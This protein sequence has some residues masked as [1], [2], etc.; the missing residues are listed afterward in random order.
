MEWPAAIEFR[1]SRFVEWPAT[2]GF[3]GLA[4]GDFP[5]ADRFLAVSRATF[6]REVAFWGVGG[7]FAAGRSLSGGDRRDL[8][9]RDRFSAAIDEPK[10]LRF[11][12]VSIAD[13]TGMAAMEGDPLLGVGD[14]QEV[15]QLDAEDLAGRD[16][17]MGESPI[18]A[19]WCRGAGGPRLED[20]Q[21][22]A[23]QRKWSLRNCKELRPSYV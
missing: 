23:G 16:Q 9:R 19:G 20:D 21:A 5:A 22:W 7:R 2:I 14:D 11:Q 13:V 12:Q 8:P 6:R 1:G 15:A 4:T 10:L 17:G 3:R 18:L